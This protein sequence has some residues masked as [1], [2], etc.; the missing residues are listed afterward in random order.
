MESKAVSG[1]QRGR[2]YAGVGGVLALLGAILLLTS[3]LGG[4]V[5][6]RAPEVYAQ[7][8]DGPDLDIEKNS[9]EHAGDPGQQLR[10]YRI[11]ASLQSGT[12]EASDVV[13]ITDDVDDQLVIVAIHD[14]NPDWTCTTVPPAPPGNLITCTLND[15]DSLGSQ[16]EDI[17]FFDV[18]D[19]V[20]RGSV[21]NDAFINLNGTPVAED[22]TNPNVFPCEALTPTATPTGTPAT[23]T[24][25][26]TATPTPPAAVAPDIKP[27]V[28]GTG[29]GASDDG[30]STAW[31]GL[32]SLLAVI[33]L[34]GWARR[35]STRR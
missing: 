5:G 27:P 22:T 26:A 31:I 20:V 8:P 1:G 35:Q 32:A 11:R 14:V 24:A 7:V 13:T 34:L 6:G 18:C 19:T 10:E 29:G 12:L 2:A 17:F 33:G 16:L 9:G 15:N 4:G 28:T 21:D 30:S 3:V 23:P 25:T